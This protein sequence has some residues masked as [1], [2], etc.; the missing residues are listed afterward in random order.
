MAEAVD[1]Y[2]SG[3]ASPYASPY[4]GHPRTLPVPRARICPGHAPS[5]GQSAAKTAADWPPSGGVERALGKVRFAQLIHSGARVLGG[6]AVR[7][8]C[9]GSLSLTWLPLN[10]AGHVGLERHNRGGSTPRSD[11]SPSLRRP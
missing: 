1:P 9:G 8:A 3:Y 7:A 4:A 10:V 2:A 6:P 11:R 5:W